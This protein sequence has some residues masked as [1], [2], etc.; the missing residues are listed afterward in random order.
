[1]AKT[2]P[3]CIL[4]Y[5]LSKTGYW[6]RE[7]RNIMVKMGFWKYR[8]MDGKYSSVF[9]LV[10]SIYHLIFVLLLFFLVNMK[11]DRI[12]NSIWYRTKRGFSVRFHPHEATL[13]N[14]SL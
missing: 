12:K 8:V 5:M 13:K 10:P 11:T 2:V 1:M 7:N 6:K 3:F 9:V 4:F 14:F